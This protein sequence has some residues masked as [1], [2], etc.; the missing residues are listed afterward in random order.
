MSALLGGT[1]YFGTS[2][3]EC[4]DPF[5]VVGPDF[6]VNVIFVASSR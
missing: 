3:Q 6:L 5:G 1:F 2:E 4:A